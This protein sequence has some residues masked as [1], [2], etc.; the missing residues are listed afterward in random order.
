MYSPLDIF[1]GPVLSPEDFSEWVEH[2]ALQ[3]N[4]LYRTVGAD[5][6]DLFPRIP[7]AI[8]RVKHPLIYVM[9]IVTAHKPG[10]CIIQGVSRVKG[11][12]PDVC[13]AFEALTITPA[14]MEMRE[15]RHVLDLLRKRLDSSVLIL[16]LNAGLEDVPHEPVRHSHVSTLPNS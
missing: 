3:S 5:G 8:D 12:K 1:D 11:F 7:L 9:G 2:F 6:K 4:Y 15:R 13:H 16:A 10:R 14:A